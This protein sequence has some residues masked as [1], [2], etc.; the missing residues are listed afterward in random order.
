MYLYMYMYTHTQTHTHMYMYTH[1]HTH[2]QATH[3][4]SFEELREMVLDSPITL[5]PSSSK[6]V[7]VHSGL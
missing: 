4:S 6:G 5:P 1:T 3:A 2:T 7:Y